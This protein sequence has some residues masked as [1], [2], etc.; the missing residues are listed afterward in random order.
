MKQLYPITIHQYATAAAMGR[1]AGEHAAQLIRQAQDAGARA[2]VMLA[3]APSQAPTLTALA[4]ADVDFGRIDFFHM[5]D[6]LGLPPDAPQ[7]FG[8]WLDRT[9]FDRTT[10]ST[11]HRID[12]T[13]DPDQAADRYAELLG[14]EPF[15]LTLCGLGVNGHLA[16]NDPPAD[17]H[18]HRSVRVVTLDQVSRQQQLDEGHFPDLASVPTHA[19]TVTIP[20]LLNAEHVLCSVIGRQKRQAVINT[21]DKDPD[22]SLPGTALKLHPDAH[23][24]VDREA[25]D[26]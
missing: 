4:A 16:F 5:D 26:A 10:G 25:Y 11:F 21:L 20:R 17:F 3:A 8:N 9:F 18:D 23:L 19:I 22:P 24:Y 12:T 1:Q 6:Y 15:D 2:R 7:G 13:L 14:D